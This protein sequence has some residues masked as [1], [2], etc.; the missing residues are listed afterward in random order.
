[1][2]SVTLTVGGLP[3]GEGVTWAYPKGLQLGLFIT[4]IYQLTVAG[5]DSNA[6]PVTQIFRVYRFRRSVRGW[7]NSQGCRAG[8]PADPHN[9]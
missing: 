6:R 4:P 5:T 2:R 9:Q 1:M 7:Q 8:G 3:I